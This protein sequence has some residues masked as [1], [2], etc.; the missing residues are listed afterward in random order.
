M[1]EEIVEIADEGEADQLQGEGD[2]CQEEDETHSVKS[3]DATK[4]KTKKKKKK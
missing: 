2:D 3:D 1:A 4:K